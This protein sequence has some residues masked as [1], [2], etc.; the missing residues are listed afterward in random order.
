MTPRDDATSGL[1]LRWVA[2]ADEDLEVLDR[3]ST[4]R[5]SCLAAK[6]FHSQQAAEKYI[7][8]LLTLTAIIVRTVEENART[9]GVR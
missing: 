4:D 8:A 9:R 1:V 2:K 6:A 7:K 3:L 5:D